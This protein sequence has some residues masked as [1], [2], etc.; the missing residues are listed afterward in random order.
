MSYAYSFTCRGLEEDL[1]NTTLSIAHPLDAAPEEVLESFLHFMH[2][3]Y[4]WDVRSR[5]G[6]YLGK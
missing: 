3:V 1:Q 4:G 6:E 5:L 2:I